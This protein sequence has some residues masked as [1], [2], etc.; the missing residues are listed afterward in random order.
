MEDNKYL[1]DYYNQD[2]EDERLSDKC[3]SVEFSTTMRYIEKYLKPDDRILE[4]GAGTGRYSHTLAQKGYS[5]DAIE[6][7]EH[8][9]KRFKENTTECEKV[10]ITQGNA[11]DLS[12]FADET[13]DITLLLGPMYHLYTESDK[14]TAL[15]EAIRVTKNGGVIFVAYC[16]SDAAII[17]AC[18]VRR[19]P[20]IFG[21]IEKGLLDT[22]TFEA[23][24]GPEYLFEIVR[25]EKI[26]ELISEFDDVDRLHYVATD[27]MTLHISETVNE[28]DE[29]L[30]DMYLKYHYATCERPDLVGQTHH[31]LDI[32]KKNK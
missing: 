24:S 21:Q 20:D 16:I 29:A 8:N 13:Y 30:F 4:I 1:I 19:N 26:D 2:R 5:V 17:T 3:G 15:S 28:M 6:L 23:R 18:F 14:K 31:S 22:E 27:G 32:L 25:K 9:I 7:I 10:T 12:A 11:L